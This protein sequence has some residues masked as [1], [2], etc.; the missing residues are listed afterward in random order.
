LF[1]AGKAYSNLSI[2]TGSLAG[3]IGGAKAFSDFALLSGSE[4]EF[5]LKLPYLDIASGSAAA[6]SSAA[7]AYSS[8][9]VSA[10]SQLALVPI[11]NSE[12][13]PC[14][15]LPAGYASDGINITIKRDLLPAL[16]ED[17]VHATSGDLRK[18]VQALLLRL[19]SHLAAMSQIDQLQTVK[20][21]MLE[22]WNRKNATFGRHSKRS[23]TLQ[24]ITTSPP[25]NVAEP[26]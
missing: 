3:L 11:I 14:K 20:S 10:G 24:F 5:I 8:F 2:S 9:L 22:D 6:L 23:F 17:E 16:S 19:D 1:S 26:E 12:F 4:I 25:A 21:F 15:I 18:I 7:K 13:A